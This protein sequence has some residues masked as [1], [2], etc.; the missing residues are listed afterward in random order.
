MNASK[1]LWH[2]KQSLVALMCLPQHGQEP[3]NT[4]LWENGAV[5][6]GCLTMLSKREECR[7]VNY[8]RQ[9]FSALENAG[10]ERRLLKTTV[11]FDERF[12]DLMAFKA[13][14]GHCNVPQT[15]ARNNKYYSL[16]FWC[17]DIRQRHKAIKEVRNP[18]NKLSKANIQ[19]LENARFEWNRCKK[20][21]FDVRFNY[22]MGFKAEFG[23]CNVSQTRSRN[24]K[25]YS[26]GR[27][28]SDTRQSYKGYQ[29]GR[30]AE[31]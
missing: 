1:T 19:R 8:S 17:K 29:K 6:R 10:F 27:W 14:F 5:M 15:R 11:T 23:H 25:H 20:I 21:A 12:K 26:L 22:L 18:S 24:N 16:G 31:M 7:I 13:E 30:N 3:I 2:L 4:V 9:T 28:C